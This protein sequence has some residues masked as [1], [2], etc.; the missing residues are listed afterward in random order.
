VKV[1]RVG[2]RELGR[3]TVLSDGSVLDTLPGCGYGVVPFR[4]LD[5]R[6]GRHSTALAISIDLAAWTDYLAFRLATAFLDRLVDGAVI[7][8][9]TDRSYRAHRSSTTSESNHPEA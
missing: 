7:L 2:S 9:L 4:L 5:A 6:A 3:N 8:N 1:I